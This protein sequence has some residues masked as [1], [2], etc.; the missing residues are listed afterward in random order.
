MLNSLPNDL[1]HI[2][3]V[4]KK[5]LQCRLIIIIKSFETYDFYQLLTLRL[6][7]LNEL[8]AKYLENTCKHVCQEL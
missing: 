6:R 3:L 1:I 4:K 7:L 8:F 2:H 5:K